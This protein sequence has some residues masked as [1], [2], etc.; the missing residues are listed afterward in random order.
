M[1]LVSGL[2]I[3]SCAFV[4]GILKRH[5]ILCLLEWNAGSMEG[6]QQGSTLSTAS[7]QTS[8]G[9]STQPLHPQVLHKV[10]HL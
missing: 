3:G 7:T 8:V 2:N 4:W 1:K 9:C 10:L 6:G 5:L